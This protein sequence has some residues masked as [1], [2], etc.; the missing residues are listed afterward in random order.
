MVVV[1]KQQLYRQIPSVHEMLQWPVS[2]IVRMILLYRLC[3]HDQ[4]TQK[5]IGAG[6]CT[7]LDEESICALEQ[8]KMRLKAPKLRKVI[9]G[10]GW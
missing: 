8:E 10:T 2:W 1:D 5:S 7:F 9:N 4:E 6:T 3:K